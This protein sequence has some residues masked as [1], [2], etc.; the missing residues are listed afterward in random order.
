MAHAAAPNLPTAKSALLRAIPKNNLRDNFTQ[1]A[2]V[3][4]KVPV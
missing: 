4:G 1:M 2:R 3:A